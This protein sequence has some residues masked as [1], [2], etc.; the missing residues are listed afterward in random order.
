MNFKDR[1]KRYLPEEEEKS[2]DQKNKILYEIFNIIKDALAEEYR[3]SKDFLEQFT[4]EMKDKL[5]K[6]S[7]ILHKKNSNM[8]GQ[9][10]KDIIEDKMDKSFQTTKNKFFNSLVMRELPKILPSE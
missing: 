7:I 3:E 10:I 4:D 8:I 5:K 6:D 2:D 9:F 1:V